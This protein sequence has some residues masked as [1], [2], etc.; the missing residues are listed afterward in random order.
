MEPEVLYRF[1]KNP[2]HAPISSQMIQFT[3]SYQFSLKSTRALIL[4]SHLRLCIPFGFFLSGSPTKLLCACFFFPMPVTW[5]A[6]LIFFD[7]MTD[8]VWLGIQNKRFLMWCNKL[9]NIVRVNILM[10]LYFGG[11]YYLHSNVRM[12]WGLLY[13]WRNILKI[14]LRV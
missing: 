3:P 14:Y 6:H 10:K 9:K 12:S 1:R 8:N 11:L 5:S 7:L 4:S 13:R 2:R